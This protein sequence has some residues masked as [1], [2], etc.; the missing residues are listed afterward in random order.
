MYDVY[1]T[2]NKINYMKA[3]RQYYIHVSCAPRFLFIAQIDWKLL[4]FTLD[5]FCGNSFSMTMKCQKFYRKHFL[6]PS[7]IPMNVSVHFKSPQA[8]RKLSF[9]MS[10]SVIHQITRWKQL[11]WISMQTYNFQFSM[12]KR[13]VSLKLCVCVCVATRHTHHWINK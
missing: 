12:A 13:N 8:I 7:A 6:L 10:P 1:Y 2:H 4:A 9:I 5:I 3:F 11:H